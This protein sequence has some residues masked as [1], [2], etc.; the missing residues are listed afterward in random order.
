MK[1]KT[2][3]L[4]LSCLMVIAMV[5]TSCR[6][7]PVEEE[8]PVVEEKK[9]A[10][11]EKKPV[12]EEKKPAVPEKEMV[13]DSLG[14]L[15]EKPQYGGTFYLPMGETP[16]SFNPSEYVDPYVA[17]TSIYQ[18]L[19]QPTWK[20][21]PSG[22]GEFPNNSTYCPL[23]YTEGCLAESWEQPDLQTV[24]FH[25]R[26]GMRWPNKPPVNGRE[27]T[28]EDVKFCYD[29]TQTRP[30]SQKYQAGWEITCSNKYT[31]VVK[32]PTPDAITGVGSAG[33]GFHFIWP[34]ELYETWGD[35]G[36]TD[37]E[38]SCGSGPWIV[39]DYVSGSSFSLER[40][41]NYW[42]TDPFF[43]ENRLPY[44]DRIEFLSIPDPATNEAALRTGKI[45]RSA[46]QWDK[47]ET[48]MQTNP[49]LLWRRTPAISNIVVY[50]SSAYETLL[51]KRVRHALQMAIDYRGIVDELYRGNAEM[52]S[53]PIQATSGEDYFTP[54]EKLPPDLKELWSYNPAK[55]K[56]LLADAGYP[57]GF[58]AEITTS[59]AYGFPDIWSLLQ[60]YWADI[61]VDVECTIREWAVLQSMAYGRTLPEFSIQ[62]WGGASPYQVYSAHGKQ[63][64]GLWNFFDQYDQRLEDLWAQ[65]QA[66]LDPAEQAAIVKEMNLIAMDLCYYIPI[67][68]YHSFT[69][70]QP[71]VKG[72]NGEADGGMATITG[73]HETA[74]YWWLDQDLKFQLTGKR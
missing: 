2:V 44:A 10:V 61:G 48:L 32:M 51:D 57:N 73:P 5:L 28:A 54:Y 29:F 12:A 11:E 1:S 23:I 34:R 16:G 47:A 39:D 58:K 60:V 38:K 52:I 62:W 46:A 30:R 74:K 15:V 13:V 20:R 31:V 45:D 42:E 22:T 18:V 37:W 71:W 33:S 8:K 70:W 14:R 36:L 35:E 66:T 27:I 19:I 7:A 24:I 53:W 4:M 68:T 65:A 21:G 26:K 3:W 63:Y 64:I 43:P 69:F 40:N 9:P 55:A 59:A 72:Y 17:V 6:A 56:Q 41:P 49:E 25:I 50:L 67:P